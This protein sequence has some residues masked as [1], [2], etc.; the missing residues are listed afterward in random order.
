MRVG[1]LND[2][3]IGIDHDAGVDDR[4]AQP[5]R[6]SGAVAGNSMAVEGHKCEQVEQ[7]PV[8][9]AFEH[10]YDK[11]LVGVVVVG[12][13]NPVVLR[14]VVEGHLLELFVEHGE[15]HDWERSEHHVVELIDQWLVQSLST[16]CRCESKP[17]KRLHKQLILVEHVVSE[18]CISTIRLAPMI[19]KQ[20]PQ[21]L[22]L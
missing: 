4:R 11:L 14:V 13:T 6:A 21:I 7:Q 22:E 12:Q 20:R 10:C 15:P 5:E 17:E 9:H 1:A 19:E 18:G 2:P 16:E 8:E 3:S